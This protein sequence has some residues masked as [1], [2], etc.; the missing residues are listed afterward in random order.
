[1]AKYPHPASS[2]L[3]NGSARMGGERFGESWGVIFE[4][5]IPEF[6]VALGRKVAATGLSFEEWLPAHEDELRALAADY[7]V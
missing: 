7:L 6:L 1:M 3:V 2:L 5:R 4:E